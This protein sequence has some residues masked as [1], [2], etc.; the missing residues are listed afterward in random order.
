MASL[1][2]K[3]LGKME[4]SIY[5]ALIRLGSRFDGSPTSKYLLFRK[6]AHIRPEA[7]SRLSTAARYY[8]EGVLQHLFSD[9]NKKLFIP[10]ENSKNITS[11]IKSEFRNN[12]SS[13]TNTARLDAAFA[14]IRKLSTV[15]QA[16]KAMIQNNSQ[17]DL[18]NNDNSKLN[19][20]GDGVSDGIILVDSKDIIL[21]AKCSD[22]VKPGIVLAAHPMVKG[23][24]HRSVILVLEHNEQGSYGV[25]VN[26]PTHHTLL[27]AVKNLP[28]K[29]T[30]KFGSSLISFGGMVRR[31]QYLH[32]IPSIKGGVEI[33]Y[34]K[35]PFYSGGDLDEAINAVSKDPSLQ[36]N[37][38]FYAG[39]CTWYPQ[40][41]E[42]EIGQG[43]WIPIETQADSL[44]DIQRML[45]LS[46]NT[47][48]GNNVS[49]STNNTDNTQDGPISSGRKTTSPSSNELQDQEQ[50]ILLRSLNTSDADLRLP[51]GL[52]AA[53]ASAIAS[54]EHKKGTY[55][56]TSYATEQGGQHLWHMLFNQLPAPY[57]LCTYL[58]NWADAG[59]IESLDWGNH[60][61]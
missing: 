34:C 55:Y 60:T 59:S 27:T 52:R 46:E 18:K 23:P 36:S 51:P 32:N 13:F 39:A 47:G 49:I 11:I 25:V 54:T 15:W 20:A 21:P 31:L 26:A 50:V 38:H 29:L 4:T 58:P 41:L 40:Q 30:E 37:F 17:L 6:T 45:T 44:I 35:A 48:S 28:S 33:P 16:Y 24:L 57:N 2:K 56:S 19:E 9:E 42:K 53:G 10:T 7:Q 43:Y 8:Q 5:R 1:G 3:K 12:D 14:V 61:K 22:I